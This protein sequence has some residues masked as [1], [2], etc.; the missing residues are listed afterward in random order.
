M[1]FKVKENRLADEPDWMHT[2]LDR[3]ENIGGNLCV[4]VTPCNKYH[5]IGEEPEYLCHLLYLVKGDRYTDPRR[6]LCMKDGNIIKGVKYKEQDERGFFTGETVG[7][8]TVKDDLYSIDLDL[9]KI[10]DIW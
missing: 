1:K 6:F 9:N 7:T 3:W 4:S 2:W 8:Y 5:E 10:E